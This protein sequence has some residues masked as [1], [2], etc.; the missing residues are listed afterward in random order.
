[1]PESTKRRRMIWRR[2]VMVGGGLAAVNL[3]IGGFVIAGRS[4]ESQAL[5]IEVERVIPAPGSVIAPQDGVQVDL[6]DEYTGVL[7][8][9]GK[10]IPLDQLTVVL[11][12][13][14]VSFRPAPGLD[15][16]RFP[17]GPHVVRV[18]YWRQAESREHSRAFV[19]RFTA[20]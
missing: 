10:E 1:M 16:T 3:F 18:V 9:D 14:Q 5:P 13:G 12:L 11:P 4:S 2:I 8:I 20:G 17:P 6:A 7:V 15:I 19:W